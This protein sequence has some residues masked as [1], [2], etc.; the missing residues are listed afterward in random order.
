MLVSFSVIRTPGWGRDFFSLEERGVPQW[1][2]TALLKPE[3]MRFISGISHLTLLVINRATAPSSL[4]RS[5]MSVC[6]ATSRRGIGCLDTL[7]TQSS[8]WLGEVYEFL[9]VRHKWLNFLRWSWQSPFHETLLKSE[10]GL[11]DEDS[12]LLS[13]SLI[14][15]FVYCW[16][17]SRLPQVPTTFSF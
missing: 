3:N 13:Y 16:N 15:C 4:M 5:V 2:R 17:M 12:Q 1:S 7:E 14:K 6:K 9:F 10:D 11:G 8:I